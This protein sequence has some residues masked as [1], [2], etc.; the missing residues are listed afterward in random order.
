LSSRAHSSSRAFSPAR[1]VLARKRRGKTKEALAREAGISTRSLTAYE[2]NQKHPTPDTITRL[3]EALE[4][5]M[6]FFHAGDIEEVPLGAASFRAL[7][8][9]TAQQRDRAIGSAA[10]AIELSTWIDARLSLPPADVPRWS[11]VQPEVA[12]GAIRGEWGLGERP[13]PNMI[14]LLE[15]HGVRVFSLVEECQEIDAYSFWRGNTPFIF[16]NT[17]KSAER[18]R[19]DAAHEL[20]H[21]C[22]HSAHHTPR[23]RAAEDDAERFASAFLM[24][25]AS[26]KSRLTSHSQLA[27]LVVQKR[28][29]GVSVAA[30]V[31]TMHSLDL[32]SDWQYRTLFIEISRLGYRKNEP[33]SMARETSQLLDKVFALLKDQGILRADVACAINIT[34]IE[35]AKLV[36]GLLPV[37]TAINGGGQGV[38]GARRTGH[39]SAVPGGNASQHCA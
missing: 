5:P 32:L 17:F 28:Y 26:M 29:W 31:R 14:H 8:N 6:G 33:N 24:P 2:K 7:S 35:L 34:P 20:G 11:R 16:L 18:S 36:F 27:D 19:M 30:L 9:L 38:Q 25:A 39:L 1:L 4:F 23:G 13:V 22:L 3:A 15:A 10:L 21:L 12:A 37:P